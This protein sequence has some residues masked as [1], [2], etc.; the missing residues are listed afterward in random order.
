VAV[1]GSQLEPDWQDVVP[2]ESD[3]EK[4]GLRYKQLKSP[5]RTLRPRIFSFMCANERLISSHRGSHDFSQRD[6]L[7]HFSTRGLRVRPLA[8]A[9]RMGSAAPCCHN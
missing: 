2:S 5:T 6:E 9:T 8:W 4:P 3:A 7:N 1:G